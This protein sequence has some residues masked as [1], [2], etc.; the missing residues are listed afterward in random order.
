V[1]ER[2]AVKISTIRI[3]INEGTDSVLSLRTQVP[4]GFDV[5]KLPEEMRVG[6]MQYAA[7][8][9]AAKLKHAEDMNALVAG[10]YSVEDE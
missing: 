8:E 4:G 2:A 7:F 5:D 9:L 10:G 6:L 1:E 3:T